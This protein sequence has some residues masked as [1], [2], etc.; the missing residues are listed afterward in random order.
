VGFHEIEKRESQRV[1]LCTRRER[2][3]R[4]REP[5]A[6][7]C[8]IRPPF[9]PIP[10]CRRGQPQIMG[11]FQ[12]AIGWHLTRLLSPINAIVLHILIP[13]RFSYPIVS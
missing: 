3:K 4:C 12:N 7:F 13:C 8:R 9:D 2:N 5:L 6:L 11:R 10:E 1:P